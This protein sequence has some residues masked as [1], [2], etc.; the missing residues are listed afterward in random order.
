MCV[1][2]LKTFIRGIAAL[3][4]IRHELLRLPLG[5]AEGIGYAH[6]KWYFNVH[7][8]HSATCWFIKVVYVFTISQ[9]II[10]C[11]YYMLATKLNLM[12]LINYVLHLSK[13]HIL[14][15]QLHEHIQ[16]HASV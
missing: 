16:T 11:S 3:F 4:V 5:L 6:I 1:I 9:R 12:I 13:L 14:P 7:S 10:I 15:M 8:A 2:D